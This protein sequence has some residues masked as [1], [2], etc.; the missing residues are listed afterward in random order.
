MAEVSLEFL[1]KKVDDLQRRVKSDSGSHM[2]TANGGGGGPHV[3][4]MNER[5]ARLEGAFDWLKVVLTLI[6]AIM[7]GGFA[8]LGVQVTRT[9][10][11]LAALD[12]R[13]AALSS[14]IAGLP[15]QINADIRDLTKTLSEAI[16]AAKQTP[17]QII[18]MTP[19]ALAPLT[20][21]K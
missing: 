10:N 14:Q 12:S 15:N 8:F 11:K 19:P 20:P 7:L 3:N 16:T 18:L 9:D 1:T 17:P 5:L 4:Q 6:V 21:S 13:V 2:S